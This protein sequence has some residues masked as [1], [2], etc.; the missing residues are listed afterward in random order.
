MW[1]PTHQGSP[2][3]VHYRV[4]NLPAAM[5]NTILSL[6]E[7]TIPRGDQPATVDTLIT[8]DVSIMGRKA[9]CSYRSRHFSGYR[10]AFLAHSISV[11]S[12]ILGIQNASSTV[13]VFHTELL[14]IRELTS[15]QRNISMG[16]VM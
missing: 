6:C 14:Q 16:S 12:I 4:F 8:L 13:M 7:C 3:Y 2:G 15:Q 10:F 11:Q 9:F 5:I 1:T